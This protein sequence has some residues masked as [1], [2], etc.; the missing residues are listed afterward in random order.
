MRL[1]ARIPDEL[2]RSIEDLA[3]RKGMTVSEI[4]RDALGEY[5]KR[6]PGPLTAFDALSATGF[7]GCGEGPED[8]SERYKD[9]LTDS[10]A[11]KH[12]LR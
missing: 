3:E 2:Y 6:N 12:G 9:Y 7:I 10:L 11:K 1:N 4:V 8:L 5:L